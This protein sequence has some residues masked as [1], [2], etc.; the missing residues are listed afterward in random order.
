MNINNPKIFY[1]PWPHLI[2]ENFLDMDFSSTLKDEIFKFKNTDD[3]VMV[4]RERINKGSKNFKQIIKHNHNSNEIFK[5]LN[6]L[7]TFKTIYDYFD[8]SKMEW[9]INENLE[10]FSENYYGK[11]YDSI[12][13]KLTKFLVSKKILKTC[14]NLDFDF[15]VS[16]KGYYRQPHRDRET[17]VLNF[18]IYLNSFEEKDGGAFQ[19]FKYKN[20]SNSDQNFFSRFPDNKALN[21]EKSINPKQGMLVAFLSTPNSYHAAS[22]FLSEKYKRVFIYG[23]YSL[24][25][26]VNWKKLLKS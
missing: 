11:Q 26:K 7:E 5:F 25:K 4:N 16:G 18:L 13:E 14:I 23:S 21:Y 2:I 19:L 20:N 6:K 15:S 17:R 24:N 1:E 3:K 10:N 8:P 12:S 22:K 9:I